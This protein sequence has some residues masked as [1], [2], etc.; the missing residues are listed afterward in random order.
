[1]ILHPPERFDL[2]EWFTLL[3]AVLVLT[4]SWKLP[5]RFSPAAI[6]VIVVF[7][8]FLAQTVDSLIAV[9]PYD[10]YD[11]SDSSKY[12]I[13]DIVIYYLSYPP[14]TYL[15]LYGYDKWKFKGLPLSLYVLG[16][17]SGS[18]FL[19]WLADLSG[20]FAY[21]DWKLGYSFIVYVVVYALYVSMFNKLKKMIPWRQAS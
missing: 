16:A 3:S 12:E 5:K 2:N 4:V 6:V 21:K 10:L 8:L 19:E 13:T 1:M 14:A 18:V 7:T 20:V 9:K 11:V 17:A 15:Y